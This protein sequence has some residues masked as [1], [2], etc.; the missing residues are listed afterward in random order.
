MIV[1]ADTAP[2]N[3]LIL[4]EHIDVLAPLYREVLIPP[5]VQDELLS[6]LAPA[7]VRSWI[8]NPPEWLEFERQLGRRNRCIL[9]WTRVNEKRLLWRR[10]GVRAQFFSSMTYLGVV[11][12]ARLGLRVVGTLG[13]LLRAHEL[14]LLD[15]REAV[16][17]LKATNFNGTDDLFERFLKQA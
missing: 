17:R 12:G 16:E 14:G 11:R 10:L 8:F 13:V 9:V 6:P 3:Y 7:A 4:I 2:L 5:A 15:I 1:V